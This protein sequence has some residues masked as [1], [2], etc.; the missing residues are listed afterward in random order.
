MAPTTGKPGAPSPLVTGDVAAIQQGMAGARGGG[1]QLAAAPGA[2]PFDNR[3]ISR[4]SPADEQLA[5][6]AGPKFQAEIDAGTAAQGQQAVLANMLVDTKQ[7]MPGPYANA[8]AAVRARLAPAF[9]IDEKALAG[10]DSFEK[11]AAQLALQ[12]AGSIGAGSDSRFSVTQAANPHGGLSPQSIDLILRQLQ[13]NADYIQARQSLAQQWPVKALYNEFVSSVRPLDPRVFQYERMTDDQKVD[14]F[15][16]M[17]ER[18]QK[19]F[20]L[21]HKWAEERKLIPGG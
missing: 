16:A 15:K 4:M 12:Q 5:K 17:D 9:N 21:A 14:Y 2:S 8:V 20:M 13:G 10:H 7:F 1:V 18:A 11:L 3:P 19:A 6:E